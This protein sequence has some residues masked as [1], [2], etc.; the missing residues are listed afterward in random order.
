MNT[1][2]AGMS[3]V[4]LLFQE[5]T[6]VIASAVLQGADGG[7][8]IDPGPSTTLPVLRRE[9]ARAGIGIADLTAIL[10]THI[11][12][13]HAG[14]TGSL[15]RENPRLQ[16]YVHEKG[17]PHMADPTKLLASATR[18]YGDAMDRLWGEV[19]PVPASAIVALSGGERID[20]SGR[21]FDVAWTPGHASHHVSYFSADSGI[22]FVGDTA[23]IRPAPVT[24]V[25]PPTPP[26]DVDLEVWHDSLARIERWGADT[27]FLTHF[28]PSSPV[29][30]HLGE[31]ADHL[32]R[33]R[34]LAEQSLTRDDN[35]EGKEQ[36][37]AGELRRI[38]RQH[39]P[40]ADAQ[41]YEAAGR[42]DLNWR[43]LARYLR[44]RN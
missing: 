12:L 24:Y 26:P 43:G 42:F 39:M 22:A 4:D 38:L 36:W 31:V 6:R 11:H 29:A 8:I 41:A 19:A 17:A 37:F 30:P 7:T 18:L 3:Y 2:A 28:G 35:D 33:V 40:E 10:L 1:L 9:L 34:S 21:R 23:G 15:V 44:K 16:V 5:R 32:A 27:L 20:A 13:D 25:L 14:A